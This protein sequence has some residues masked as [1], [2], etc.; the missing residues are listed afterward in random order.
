[1]KLF[2]KKHQRPLVS[3]CPVCRGQSGGLAKSKIKKA[4][5]RVNGAK[6]GRPKRKRA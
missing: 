1:M 4:A 3:F 5:A 6:G 2:C